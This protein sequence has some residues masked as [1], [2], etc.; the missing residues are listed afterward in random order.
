MKSIQIVA[1][2]LARIIE[3]PVPEPQAGEVVVRVRAVT[4]CPQWDL[5]LMHGE[6]MF[7]GARIEY[8]YTPGQPGHEAA[9]EI[10]AV[11]R[12]VRTFKEGDRVVA[13]RDPGHSHPGCYAEYVAFDP[14]NLLPLPSNAAFADY[15]SFELAMCVGS[16]FLDILGTTKL[17]GKRVGVSGLGGSGLIAAQMAK[18]E[19]AAEVTGFETNARREPLARQLGVDRVVDP[20]AV[21]PGEFARAHGKLD[22]ALDCVGAKAAAEYLMG[23]TAEVVALFGV[24]REGYVFPAGAGRLKLFGY[25]GHTREAA[26]Y[27]MAQVSSGRVRLA[28]L[29]GAQ[30]PLEA[31][32]EAIGLLER[33]EVLKVCFTP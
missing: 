28:P 20:S 27:A 9:G 29:S 16:S 10:A 24:Q 12:E 14:A 1:P 4:T 5:H 31:Y 26:N 2:R 22:V 7:A 3:R 33:Q 13:W 8:P 17:K 25:P 30:R 11:G 23:L 18:A 19:G 21:S 32:E 6:P 15:A